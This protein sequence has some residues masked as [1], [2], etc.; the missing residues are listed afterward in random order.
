MNYLDY[1]IERRIVIP[2]WLL[3]HEWFGDTTASRIRKSRV[4]KGFTIRELAS[5]IG[6]T[7]TN[8]ISIENSRSTP[9]LPTLRL[10]SEAL[11]VPVYYIG[12]FEALSER[13]LGEKILKARCYHGLTKSE[14]AEL[15]EVD[16]KTIKNWE[17]DTRNPL[18]S[19]MIKLLQFNKIIE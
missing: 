12:C 11:N 1:Y 5:S 15:F 18:S 7:E 14:M 2:V 17:S 4:E 13:T 19:N 16:V 10:L 3:G 9:S 8:I 6:M